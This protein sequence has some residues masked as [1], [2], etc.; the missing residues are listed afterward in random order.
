MGET[1]WPMPLQPRKE[2]RREWL[3][4]SL[5]AQVLDRMNTE[6]ELRI[7][8]EDGKRAFEAG[9]YQ[10]AAAL[11]GSAADGY[12]ALQ[13]P[14]NEAEQRNN[15]SVALLKLGRA[16]EALDSVLGTEAVFS[17][18]GDVRRAGMALNNQAVALENLGREAEALSA[19]EKAS[20]L[21]TQAGEKE[22][23]AIVLKAAAGLQLR[24]G[25]LAESG[26]RMIGAM[27]AKPNPSWLDRLL[28]SIL[29]LVQ[30]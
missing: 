8:A 25:K 22:M 3:P 17:G 21:L 12:A 30:R 7:S 24:R 18:V 14:V 6:V 27:E 15:L 16:Q 23:R 9:R 13:D 5:G 29:R 19:Y 26:L 2:E 4:T 28:R 1:I 10:D 11:F 20:E